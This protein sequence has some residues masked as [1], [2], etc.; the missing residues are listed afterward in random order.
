M[1]L[2][3]PV[4]CYVIAL[5]F[6]KLVHFQG[7]EDSGVLPGS[8]VGL[9]YVVAISGAVYARDSWELR[10]I[11]CRLLSASCVGTPFVPFFSGQSRIFQCYKKKYISDNTY[12]HVTSTR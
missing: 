5:P 10:L 7:K 4:L 1:P 3:V 8:S 9:R 11:Q 12:K 2:Y 6:L